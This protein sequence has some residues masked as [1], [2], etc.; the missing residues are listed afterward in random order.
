MSFIL[1][2]ARPEDTVI[3]TKNESTSEHVCE[4]G[5]LKLKVGDKL[6]TPEENVTCECIQPPMVHCIQSQ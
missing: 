6:E 3:A 4:F 2:S 1:I 5:N